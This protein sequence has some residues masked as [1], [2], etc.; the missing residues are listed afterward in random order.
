MYNQGVLAR[1]RYPIMR[2]TLLKNGTADIL[3]VV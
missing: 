2:D 3:F 1:V